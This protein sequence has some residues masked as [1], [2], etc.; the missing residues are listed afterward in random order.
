ML[1][2]IKPLHTA[3]TK[4]FGHPVVKPFLAHTGILGFAVEFAH[5]AIH[6]A[7]HVA[8]IAVPAYVVQ[9]AEAYT[10]WR[11]LNLGYAA[12]ALGLVIYCDNAHHVMAAIKRREAAQDAEAVPDD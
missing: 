3:T 6:T 12:L 8:A 4:V 1:K 7:V 5:A 9:V 11:D 10:P 2:V